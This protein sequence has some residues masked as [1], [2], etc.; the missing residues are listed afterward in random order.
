MNSLLTNRVQS[1]YSRATY[2]S[3]TDA[4][5]NDYPQQIKQRPKTSKS[6]HRAG[7]NLF[8]HDS[9]R[10]G[11]SSTLS[12][13]T[14]HRRRLKTASSATTTSSRPGS[15][16]LRSDEIENLL[17]TL[18]RDDT[19][20]VQLDCLANYRTLVETIDLRH[21]PID[22]RLLCALQQ[23]ENR[24]VQGNACR[25][26][27]FHSLLDLLQ[28]AYTSATAEQNSLNEINDKPILEYPHTEIPVEYVK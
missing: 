18:D 1:A 4:D 13:A 21:T 5:D 11:N 23:R 12:S 24:I 28:P 8:E 17:Q 9:R 16:K 27:R 22:S 25:D 14:S 15:R 7:S 6:L 26:T 2:R 3:E 10:N 19:V 20:I